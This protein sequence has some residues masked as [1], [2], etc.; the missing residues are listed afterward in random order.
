MTFSKRTFLKSV[1]GGAVVA[2][3]LPVAMDNWGARS[4]SL[5]AYAKDGNNGN[6]NGGGN[7]NGNGGGNGNGNGGGNGNG[8]GGGNGNSGGGNGNGSNGNGKGNGGGAGVTSNTTAS[9]SSKTANTATEASQGSDGSIRIR[10]R[11]GITEAIVAGR[12]V[13]KDSKGRTISNRQATQ[14]DLRRLNR[15]FR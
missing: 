11:N 15:Y 6:G 3:F 4:I 14:A 2:A 1:V 9:S 12:Y 8:N 13:M 10:H 5:D 7:G